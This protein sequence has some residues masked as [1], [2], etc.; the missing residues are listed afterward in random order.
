MLFDPKPEQ[1]LGRLETRIRRAQ[2][3]TPE[4]MS[5]VIREACVCPPARG[6]AAKLRIKRLIESGAWIDAVLAL[7]ELELPQWKLRRI[8]YED[9][10]WHC[11]LSRQP[12]LP[13]E[14]DDVTEASHEILTLA[15]LLAL[16][17][18][19]RDAALSATKVVAVVPRVAP[20]PGCAMCCDNFT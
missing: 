19:A 17:Q 10:E 3:V 9:G 8:V 14:L 16:L 13:L 4:L 15:I 11:S 20:A 12:Q 7:L 5:D 2:A 6:A 18:A 1:Y